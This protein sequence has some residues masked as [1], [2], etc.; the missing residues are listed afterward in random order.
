MSRPPDTNVVIGKWIFRHKLT[1]DGS[2]ERYKACWVLQGFTRRPGV[3]YVKTFSPIVK[4][5]NVQ[6]VHSL[7]LS[8]DWAVHQ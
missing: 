7:P 3:D 4:F 6:A 5:A 1:S 2:L 8:W